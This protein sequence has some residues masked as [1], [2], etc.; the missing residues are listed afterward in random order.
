MSGLTD[1][2]AGPATV[3][4]IRVDTIETGWVASLGSEL[5][6]GGTLEA[7][8][9]R[10]TLGREAAV[11]ASGVDVGGTV[12]RVDATEVA[13]VNASTLVATASD[14]ETRLAD[15]QRLQNARYAAAIGD[16][17]APGAREHRV[18]FA[19][20]RLLLTRRLRL[21]GVIVQPV[22]ERPQ[23]DEQRLM[24]DHVRGRSS[25]ICACCSAA[26]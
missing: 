4:L 8:W 9:T 1:L 18:V 19:V 20:E 25:A 7:T 24:V 17:T 12:Q 10:A 16:P 15:L 22:S 26:P 23:G 14:A 5:T 2:P 3:Q 21:P 13:L 6:P 11:Y